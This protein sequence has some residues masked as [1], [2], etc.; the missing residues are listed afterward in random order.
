MHAFDS[1]DMG[2]IPCKRSTIES[3]GGLSCTWDW[4]IGTTRPKSMVE[5]VL[6]GESSLSLCTTCLGQVHRTLQPDRHVQEVCM[7][8][9][10]PLAN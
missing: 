1:T 7:L 5:A 4:C 10:L 8:D 3:T 6:I 2:K 9:G